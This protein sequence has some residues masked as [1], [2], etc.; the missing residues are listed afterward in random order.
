MTAET[1][2][3]LSV[4]IAALQLVEALNLYSARGKL[5]VIA[6][7]ISTVEFIWLV[8]CVYALFSISFPGWTIFLPAAYVSYF[9]VATW[10]SAHIA[11]EAENLDDFRE[12]VVPKN[13]VLIS[14]SF[15]VAHLIASGLA[16]LQ[17]SGA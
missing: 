7:A 8:T 12:I 13:L 2:I 1:F 11:K 14:L 3:T 16:W 5:T 10:R 17:Y 4:I 6:M 9:V 15:S